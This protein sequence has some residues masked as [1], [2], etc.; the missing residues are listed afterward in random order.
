MQG[1]ASGDHMPTVT[2]AVNTSRCARVVSWPFPGQASQVSVH[3]TRK[4]FTGEGT[5]SQIFFKTHEV[6]RTK[7]Q[8]HACS[9]IRISSPTPTLYD[10]SLLLPYWSSLFYH[11]KSPIFVVHVS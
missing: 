6:N 10:P 5:E 2:S 1:K 3:F 11:E 4:P 8:R 9:F 7:D